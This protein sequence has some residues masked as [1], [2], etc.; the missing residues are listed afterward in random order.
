MSI[1]SQAKQAV[2]DLQAAI[3]K[4]EGDE[5]EVLDAFIN[6]VGSHVDGWQMRLDELNEGEE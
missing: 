6:E 5:A 4:C 1:E 3:A 2:K